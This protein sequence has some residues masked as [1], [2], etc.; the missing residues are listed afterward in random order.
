MTRRLFSV[1]RVLPCAFRAP[2]T[3]RALSVFRLTEFFPY[4]NVLLVHV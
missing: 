3:G 1:C 4:A 2:V